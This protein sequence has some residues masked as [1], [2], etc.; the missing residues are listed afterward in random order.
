MKEH[1]RDIYLA[2]MSSRWNGI[3]DHLDDYIMLTINERLICLPK[4][5]DA[6]LWKE[7]LD[8]YEQP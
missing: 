3:A 2:L 6:Q 1:I 5:Y 8:K 7:V 4:T